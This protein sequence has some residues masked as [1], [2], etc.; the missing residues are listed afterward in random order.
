MTNSTIQLKEYLKQY[1]QP[2]LGTYSI[3]GKSAI[4][5]RDSNNTIPHQSKEGLELVIAKCPAKISN[6]M[7]SISRSWDITLIQHHGNYTITDAVEKLAVLDC[8]ENSVFLPGFTLPTSDTKIPDQAVVTLEE[9]V[10]IR[11]SYTY[12]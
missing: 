11:E 4:A 2:F 1:L 10:I 6:G 8:H 12:Q 7:N 9:S 5:I 3:A